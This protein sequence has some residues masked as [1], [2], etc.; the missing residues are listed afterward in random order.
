[1]I[2]TEVRLSGTS[3]VVW[4][5]I[6]RDR[7]LRRKAAAQQERFARQIA[8]ELAQEERHERAAED[9]AALK[10]PE[11]IVLDPHVAYRA[12]PREL[13]IDVQLPG[14]DVAPAEKSVHYIHSRGVFDAKPRPQAE[15]RQLYLQLIAQLPLSILHALFNASD[16]DVLD[17]VVINGALDTRDP[18]TCHPLPRQR[19]HQ[20]SEL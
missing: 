14:V 2:V 8:R 18:A 20:P 10:L 6:A 1:M 3:V 12:E 4:S 11:G 15:I 13:V 19:H 9:R 16:A 5:E 17:S 7:E